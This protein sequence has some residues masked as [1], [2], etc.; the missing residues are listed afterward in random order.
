MKESPS[1]IPGFG[2]RQLPPLPLS[3][4]PSERHR[5]QIESLLGLPGEA[6]KLAGDLQEALGESRE[7]A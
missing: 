3:L 4:Q 5:E 1:L 6:N 2:G 7:E